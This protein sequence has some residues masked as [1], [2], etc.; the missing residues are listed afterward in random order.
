MADKI[1]IRKAHYADLQSM[2]VLLEE[3]F[4]IE[5][6]FVI[7]TQK[8]IRGLQ[9]L[10]NTPNSIILVAQKNDSVVGM[11][12]IQQVISTA[13]GEKVGLIE[14]MVVHSDHRTEGIG[15]LLLDSLITLSIQLGCGRL[16]LGVDLRNH[17]AKSFYIRFGFKPS[18]M[19]LMY[20]I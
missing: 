3:L 15:S 14:D 8:Q 6:D 4:T 5:D 12:S 11:V 9:L 16:S 19:G 10:L 20:R 7:D 18:N 13:I 1:V 2:A 17:A